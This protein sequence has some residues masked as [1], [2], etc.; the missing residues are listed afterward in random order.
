M[1]K[2][3]KDEKRRTREQEDQWV[4]YEDALIQQ[5]AEADDPREAQLL[6]VIAEGSAYNRSHRLIVRDLEAH[7]QWKAENPEAFRQQVEAMRRA[8]R[9]HSDS[10]PSELLGQ[11]NSINEPRQLR[12]SARQR[13]QA[14]IDS[15]LAET[16]AVERAAAE[17][18][19]AMMAAEA[20]I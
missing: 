15:V 17:A 12:A 6:A 4:E 10:E 14:V 11:A 18:A 7:R 3:K 19:A 8:A 13:G 2:A 5:W 20:E 16:T 1:N 9:L